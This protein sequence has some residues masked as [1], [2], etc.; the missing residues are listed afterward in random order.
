PKGPPPFLPP[1]ILKI[2]ICCI[3]L[4]ELGEPL[5]GIAGITSVVR[6]YMLVWCK[7]NYEDKGGGTKG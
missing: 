1:K 3:L 2:N 5:K 4:G 7:N 6:M